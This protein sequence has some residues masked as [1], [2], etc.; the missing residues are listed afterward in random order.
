[1][2]IEDIKK[3]NLDPGEIVVIRVNQV[4]SGK[5]RDV[6]YGYLAGVLGKDAKVLILDGDVSID[7]LS[8]KKTIDERNITSES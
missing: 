6:M 2:Q 7:V 8:T 5:Q 3:L 1:M 4:M